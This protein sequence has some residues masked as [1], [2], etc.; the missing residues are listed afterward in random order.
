MTHWGKD[1]KGALGPLWPPVSGETFTRLLLRVA[2]RSRNDLPRLVGV[3]QNLVNKRIA[4]K[5]VKKFTYLTLADI[6]QTPEFQN[7][8]VQL[9]KA[10]ELVA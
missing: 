3:F 4:T 6:R 1:F 7:Y 9:H 2:E 5:G 8:S 10:K